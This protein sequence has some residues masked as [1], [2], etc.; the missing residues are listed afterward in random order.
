[1]VMARNLDRCTIDQTSHW[2]S[3]PSPYPRAPPGL[4]DADGPRG[5][6]NHARRPRGALSNIG[7]KMVAN[8]NNAM[9]FPAPLQD[10]F[11]GQVYFW[12]NQDNNDT[13]TDSDW[14]RPMR[15]LPDDIP[16]NGWPPMAGPDAQPG[17]RVATTYLQGNYQIQIRQNWK[18]ENRSTAPVEYALIAFP[19]FQGTSRNVIALYD[20]DRATPTDIPPDDT[21]SGAASFVSAT[22]VADFVTREL[23]L[24]TKSLSVP[25][26][27]VKDYSYLLSL[28]N[29]S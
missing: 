26:C 17:G 9:V 14:V 7:T 23:L 10:Q 29:T 5:S 25:G 1:M 8:R 13:N 19:Q 28:I 12:S 27:T 15:M 18:I 6:F 11:N 16:W 3:R 2:E 22:P 20:H 24:V 4:Y 21:D